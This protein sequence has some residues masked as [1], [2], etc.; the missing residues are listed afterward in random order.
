MYHNIQKLDLIALRVPRLFCELDRKRKCYFLIA[1]DSW[2][3]RILTSRHVPQVM[4]MPNL[5]LL[6]NCFRRKW[7]LPFLQFQ[8]INFWCGFSQKNLSPSKSLGGCHHRQKS[9]GEI[10]IQ[11]TWQRNVLCL[12][13]ILML[14][15]CKLA[16][17]D[18]LAY[19]IY[20]ISKCLLI[21]CRI[22]HEFFGEGCPQT[23]QKHMRYR[24][25]SFG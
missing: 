9:L 13:M 10:L 17:W 16:L 24:L 3:L 12:K 15:G 2:F 8:I 18:F 6:Q 19:I 5:R 1:F 14:L 4:D 7:L 21:Q 11:N 25:N 22:I 23:F 20:L